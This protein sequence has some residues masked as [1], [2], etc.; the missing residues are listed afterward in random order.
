MSE[1]IDYL[2]EVL[3]PFGP[4]QTRRMFGGYG[5]Y[6]DGV[7]FAIVVDEVLYL[8][9]DEQSAPEFE[10]LSLC[11]FE[12]L[13]QGKPVRMSFFE[14]PDAVFDDADEAVR[15]ARCAFEAALRSRK[16]HGD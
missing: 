10:A 16:S 8:K 13:K 14:A 15:W 5:V 9:A 3:A 7:M 12:Y 2:H 6:H 1:F 4:V 11:R